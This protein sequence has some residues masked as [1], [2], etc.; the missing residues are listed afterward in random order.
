MTALRATRDG[1][2]PR[3]FRP[4]RSPSI[5]GQGHQPAP[6]LIDRLCRTGRH[7]IVE[8]P[9]KESRADKTGHC[10]ISD[11]TLT[12]S[13]PSTARPPH[14]MLKMAWTACETA[15]GKSILVAQWSVSGDESRARTRAA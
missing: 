8:S 4:D 10:M 9:G 6:G 15:D 12:T 14:T 13:R 5:G 2:R 1:R 3:V 7:E 11:A